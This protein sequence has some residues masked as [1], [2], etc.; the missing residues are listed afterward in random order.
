QRRMGDHHDADG[1]AAVQHDA[2]AQRV[3]RVVQ[4][5]GAGRLAHARPAQAARPGPG[6]AGSV[7][8]LRQVD[9]GPEPDLGPGRPR[10]GLAAVRDQ[11]GVQ[12]AH[13]AVQLR[14]RRRR[15]RLRPARLVLRLGLELRKRY[16]RLH[17]RRRGGPAVGR[18][19]HRAD[20]LQ[21]VRPGQDA[22]PR[23]IEPGNQRRL[24]VAATTSSSSA[25]VQPPAQRAPVAPGVSHR[26]TAGRP[27][28]G[29]SALWFL[30]PFVILYVLFI[31]GPAIY[32]VVLSFFDTRL[33]KGGLG[34]FA[35]FHNYGEA[36]GSADFWSSL[37]HTLW[38]TIL[39]TPPLVVLSLLFAL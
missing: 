37:W 1:Q 14:G 7:A 6:Q 39:T 5:R 10:A 21:A 11:R 25:G 9:A 31:I 33:V 16:G 23:L 22:V 38:F 34:S 13:P 12:E 36:L 8:R 4:V 32:M 35:G 20:P 24:A 19:R 17:R 18:R 27:G 2:G 3:R 29:R 30:A 15:R 26:D 28:H